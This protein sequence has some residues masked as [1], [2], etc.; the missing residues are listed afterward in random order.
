MQSRHDPGELREQI[1]PI[2]D[3][4]WESLTEEQRQKITEHMGPGG[5]MI[6]ERM[7]E[8]IGQGR[9]QQWF[10]SL[11]EEQRAELQGRFRARMQEMQAGTA[12]MKVLGLLLAPQTIETLELWLE[13]N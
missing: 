7:R 8:R 11:D 12:R 5:E 10:Q 9:G 3:R 13:A 1:A 2:V 4:V 6:R